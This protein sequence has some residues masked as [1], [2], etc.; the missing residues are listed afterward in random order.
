[1]SDD[2]KY[3][4]KSV[5]AMRGMENRSIAK[6]QKEGGW[7]L[8]DQTQ[9]ML[10]TTLN[11]RRVKPETFLSK[12]WGAFR[13]LVPAK[14]RALAVAVAVFLPLAAV[15]IGTAAA[16]DQGDTNAVTTATS[17]LATAT[18]TVTNPAK[19]ACL[20]AAE[21]KTYNNDDFVCTMDSNQRLVWLSE[22]ESRKIAADKAAA[23]KAAADKA[24][25]DKAAADKAAADQAAADKAAA[26]QAA[27]NKAAADQAA[28]QPARPAPGA[29]TIICK[30]GYV[31]PG[32]TRQGACSRHGGIAN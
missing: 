7:E 11:F 12:A 3:E 25:A 23:D 19:T 31:W 18:P 6:A 8:A 27:A 20:T 1:M 21:T 15:G 16:Q 30:D 14:Q 2:I 22:E 9:G 13:G 32:T 29:G 17:P 28:R 24:A 4:Y 5:Q 10:R 26:D